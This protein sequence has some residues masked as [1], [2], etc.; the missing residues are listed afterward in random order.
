MTS[1]EIL[2]LVVT[3][4]G[5]SS[6]AAIFTILYM[7]FAKTTISEVNSGK[8]DIELLDEVIYQQQ[9]KVKKRKEITGTIKSVIFFTFIGVVTPLFVFSIVNKIQGNVTM[10][11][12]RSLMIVASSSMSKINENDF[13]LKN[14][15]WTNQFNM[16]DVIVLEKVANPVN[17]RKGDV[18]AFRV[19]DKNVKNVIHRIRNVE[20]TFDKDGK[21]VYQYETRGDSVG[22]SD[23]YNPTSDQVIGRYVSKRIPLI[24]IFVIFFQSGP[25]IVTVLALLYCLLMID[26]ITKKI[27]K[28]QN[29]RVEKLAVALDFTSEK[30]AKG[31]DAKYSETIYYKGFAYHFNEDGFISKEEVE[32]GPYLEVSDDSMIKVVEDEQTKEVISEIVYSTKDEVETTSNNKKE[33]VETTSE[34]QTE[35]EKGEDNA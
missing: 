35:K 32:E 3:A 8:R 11:G 19:N 18:I 27:D 17:L 31:F 2:A 33:E 10:L 22:E 13:E 12:N 29:K 5:V 24:G 30:N 25:G 9:T 15:G 14:S 6:F 1:V 16:Y 7:S 21:V 4:I 20:T 23:G 26:S 34:N 28:A